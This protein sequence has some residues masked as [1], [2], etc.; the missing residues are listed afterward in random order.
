MYEESDRM[1]KPG[2][3]R[4]EFCVSPYITISHF[5]M[6][7]LWPSLNAIMKNYPYDGCIQRVKTI[8]AKRTV[9]KLQHVIKR[10][11]KLTK[12]IGASG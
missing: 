8:I 2:L 1:K 11:P 3:C 10:L 9:D 12:F 6:K 5:L 7:S 4:K